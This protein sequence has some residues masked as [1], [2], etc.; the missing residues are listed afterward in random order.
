MVPQIVKERPLMFWS[1]LLGLLGLIGLL[2]PVEWAAVG[3]SGGLLDRPD[4]L[5]AF[6]ERVVEIDES[7]QNRQSVTV[8]AD[9]EFDIHVYLAS[10]RLTRAGGI[11]HDEMKQAQRMLREMHRQL[12][13]GQTPVAQK[14]IRGMWLDRIV[15]EMPRL[16]RAEVDRELINL[17]E[18]LERHMSTR[19]TSSKKRETSS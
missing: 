13:R 15:E 9:H 5:H 11:S 19:D 16:D 8:D 3:N 17:H 4:R 1:A 6:S 14:S 2:V 12:Q 18:Q 10:R 7:L